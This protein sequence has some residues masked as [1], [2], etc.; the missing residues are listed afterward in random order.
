MARHKESTRV[1]PRLLHVGR[2]ILPLVVIGIWLA[3]TGV[4][5]PYFGK[6][7]EVSTNDSTAYLPTT[8]EATQVQQR[9]PEFLGE[10]AIPAILVVTPTNSASGEELSEA[11]LADLTDLTASL[12]NLDEV[13]GEIS[14]PIP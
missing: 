6:V 2:V 14:P 5:G 4:G 10:D 8:A 13:E 1:R 11:D 9:L 3:A 12:A 7:S